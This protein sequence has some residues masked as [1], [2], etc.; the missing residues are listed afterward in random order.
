MA[1]TKSSK[2]TK[3]AANLMVRLDPKSKKLLKAAAEL[4]RMSISDYVR[5]LTVSQA[6]REVRAA[7]E[8]IISLTATEQLAFWTS[9][10]DPG[11]LTPAQKKLGAI[12]RGE[13]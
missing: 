9:L 6:E 5:T 13:A 7:R 10:N 4:R 2:A 1:T 3:Q 8:R 12:M 11:K